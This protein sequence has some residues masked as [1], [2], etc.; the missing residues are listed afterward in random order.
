MESPT[1]NMPGAAPESAP[2]IQSDFEDSVSVGNSERQMA[3]DS[4]VHETTASMPASTVSTIKLEDLLSGKIHIT[5]EMTESGAQSVV[6]E[7]MMLDHNELKTKVMVAIMFRFQHANQQDS[8]ESSISKMSDELDKR[9]A[10]LRDM[11]AA[12]QEAQRKNAEIM[13]ALDGSTRDNKRG[14]GTF[15]ISSA[16]ASVEASPIMPQIPS[17]NPFPLEE[18]AGTDG[19]DSIANQRRKLGFGEGNTIIQVAKGGRRSVMNETDK[20]AFEDNTESLVAALG[21]LAPAV[22]GVDI[23]PQLTSREAMNRLCEK[24]RKAADERTGAKLSTSLT[25]EARI[26][27]H[28]L[29]IL[30]AC[31]IDMPI[32]QKALRAESYRGFVESYTSAY[33]RIPKE[34]MSESQLGKMTFDQYKNAAIIENDKVLIA[35][36]EAGFSKLS[37]PLAA[38]C[39]PRPSHQSIAGGEQ[40]RLSDCKQY[41][42]AGL[43]Y[44]LEATRHLCQSS[45]D[46][47]LSDFLDVLDAPHVLEEVC[48]G[49]IERMLLELDKIYDWFVK[50]HGEINQSMVCGIA[51]L[52]MLDKVRKG[53]NTHLADSFKNGLRSHKFDPTQRDLRGALDEAEKAL[54]MLITEEKRHTDSSV[55]SKVDLDLKSMPQAL[56]K[57]RGTKAEAVNQA[58]EGAIK[59]EYHKG[60]VTGA[61]ALLLSREASETIM[62]VSHEESKKRL[63]DEAQLMGNMLN[64]VLDLVK[65]IEDGKGLGASD[66][67][68]MSALLKQLK[69]FKDIID[70]TS[71]AHRH[72]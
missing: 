24:V 1:G 19:P 60:L 70:G 18:E 22:V 69:G 14:E 23:M 57:H 21:L 46:T 43:V 67:E 35:V 61:G 48:N 34:S 50:K 4:G 8:L 40:E 10:E 63:A 38:R 72:A 49:S 28:T 42:G 3:R 52:I 33:K 37:Q 53:K 65:K 45:W 39:N 20:R 30:D 62:A 64:R 11:T 66:N 31:D 25:S 32:L 12:L 29:R 47:V 27:E 44:I 9:E 68:K 16:T 56:A 71:R 36:V 17:Y 2:E 59:Q 54:E 26:L 7:A 41:P 13:L 6:S 55:R 15:D 58:N 5:K 51:K